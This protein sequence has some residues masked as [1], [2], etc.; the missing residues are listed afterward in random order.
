MHFPLALIFTINQNIN[1]SVLTE[2][3]QFKNLQFKLK[4]ELKKAQIRSFKKKN[5]DHFFC[6][7]KLSRISL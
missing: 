5:D 1:L 3:L 6:N 2:H 4:K 7:A